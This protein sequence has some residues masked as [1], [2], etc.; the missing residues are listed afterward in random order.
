MNSPINQQTYRELPAAFYS[1]SPPATSPAP[2]LVALNKGLLSEYGLAPDWFESEAGLAA[3]AG[4]A[5]Y[6]SPP[7]AMAYAGHQY[8]HW[9]PLLGDG[10]AH[11]LGQIHSAD[12]RAID[13]QLKG[14][15]RTQYSRGGDGKATLGSMLREYIISEAMHGLGIPSTRSLAV[16][17]TGEKVMRE[18]ILPGGIVARTAQ[19]HIRVGSF[20]YAAA[21]Q[22][23]DGVKAL[24]DFLIAHHYPEVADS[25][26][27][28]ADLLRA[29]IEKQA[30]LIAQWMLVGFIHGVMNTDNMSVVG[31]TIDYGP[32]AF[33]DEFH[34]NKVF[35]SIDQHGRYAWGQQP[36]IAVWNLT[37]LAGTFLPLL[38]DDKEQA[39][40]AARA[41]LDTFAPAFHS[42]F[43]S[44]FARKL[45]LAPNVSEEDVVRLAEITLGAMAESRIDFTV[46]FDRL[47]QVAEGKNQAHLLELFNDAA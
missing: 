7:I 3:L 34:P 45:G 40:I 35:S 26:H 10:R 32:C 28:Y 17:A 24:A 6:A 29:I 30:P 20:Q 44:G 25:E 14:S 21:S 19:S 11:M 4:N 41:Q 42:A 39:E 8:A 33:M 15:G 47:T 12:G 31:E 27:P 43:N 18:E 22:G 38:N 46:F 37:Q 9:V 23:K 36:N 2:S 1:E 13:V 16:I 5:D